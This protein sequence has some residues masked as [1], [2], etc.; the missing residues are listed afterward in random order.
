MR[1]GSPEYFWLL[2]AMPLLVGFFM[3]AHQRKQQSLRKY[4]SAAVLP[5]LMP[6][7]GLT[8]QIVK[9][10]L[11]LLFFFFL[12]LAL[13]RPRF[14]V[15]LEMIERRGVDII[16]ALDVSES[17]LAEDI[18]PNRLE[19]AK[20]EI[21]KFI[22]LLKGDR[23][24]LIVFAGEGFVQCPLTLDYG[25]A[26]MFLDVVNTDWIQLQGTALSDAIDLA[27]ESFRSRSKKGKVLIMITDGEDHEGDALQAARKAAAEGVK[28]YTIG[29]GSDNGAP[30]PMQ[31][32]GGTIVYKK[33]NAGNLVMTRL[34]QMILEKT[35]AE[36]NGKYFHAGTNLDLTSIYDEIMKLEKADLGINKMSVYEE[37]YQIFLVLAL[38]FLLLEFFVPDRIKR[39]S[40]W[41]GR[42]A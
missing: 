4:A 1:F 35:A 26:K 37:Q 36:G 14:G 10:T 21:A 27:T 9:W 42:I 16:V 13:V 18:T 30:I 7:V 23:F 24:G 41:K 25:A 33:D 2:L 8:R 31:K 6:G 17:M 11:F 32:S 3:W 20:H 28:I 5:R 19:R 22:D 29:V 40:E 39:K 12:I 34:D 38:I 15:K